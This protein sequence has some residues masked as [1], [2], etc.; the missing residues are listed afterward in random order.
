MRVMSRARHAGLYAR[1]WSALRHDVESEEV[2]V[3]ALLHDMAEMLIWC[4]APELAMRMERMMQA[5]RRLR[6]AVAQKAML[7]L[8]LVDLQ[9]ALAKEWRLPSLL[10]ALMD[11][12]HAEVPRVQT[13]H[14]AVAL[15]RH[16]AHGWFDAAL[17]DDFAE[18]KKML[19]LADQEARNHVYRIALAAAREWEWYGVPPAACWLPLL[20]QT[21]EPSAPK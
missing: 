17:P 11:D 18:M 19:G 20:P 5:D 13:V 3:A 21:P 6:S 14:L 4:V 8:E 12:R 9:Q 15:A 7:G 1:E 2:Y 16:S 10:Q